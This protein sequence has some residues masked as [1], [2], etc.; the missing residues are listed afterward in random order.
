[1]SHT[2]HVLSSG[3]N[4]KK[5]IAM[6]KTRQHCKMVQFDIT[7]DGNTC[8][9]SIIDAGY[10]GYGGGGMG[11]KQACTATT[12]EE[13]IAVWNAKSPAS[14]ARKRTESGYGLKSLEYSMCP[15]PDSEVTYSFEYIGE[16][17]CEDY[18]MTAI[19]NKEEC[20]LA[21]AT[22][23]GHPEKPIREDAR[24]RDRPGPCLI[25]KFQRN[26]ATRPTE[27]FP[28]GQQACTAKGSGY[29]CIC[30]KP[31]SAADAV[32][33]VGAAPFTSLEQLKAAV[34]SCMS[35][36]DKSGKEC[37]S[38]HGADCGPAGKTDMPGWNVS[39]MTSLE[40]LFGWPRGWGNFQEDLSA[41]DTSSVT[42][43]AS[44][45]RKSSFSPGPKVD[46][47]D[48][49]KVTNMDYAFYKSKFNQPLSGWDVR[50]VQ[51]AHELFAYNS[52]FAQ[53]I[54]MWDMPNIGDK[55]L[56]RTF[57]GHNM[58]FPKLFVNC[59]NPS[60]AASIPECA[61]KEFPFSKGGNDGPPGAWTKRN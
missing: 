14:T 34:D 23:D 25:H 1:M 15:E 12:D 38:K 41:W 24:I 5:Y 36:G 3:A 30:K 7:K 49:S 16:G 54:T 10:A 29:D 9:Y 13:V 11:A 18:G 20:R 26:S 52:V 37:C 58:A 46:A 48:V 60:E 40:K 56:H 39:Q 44:L 2:F 19:A 57:D 31:T 27:W 6:R 51:K 43:I 22:V 28:N 8:S 59:G 45:F 47:W 32:S 4:E 61:G 50:N 33:S 35:V 53:D 55:G 21:G 42:N 17:R